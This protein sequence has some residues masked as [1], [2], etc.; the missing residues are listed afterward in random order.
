MRF[1]Y[2]VI[3]LLCCVSSLFAQQRK[4][5][6]KL[7]VSIVVDQLRTDFLYEF[8]GLYCD[9]GFKRLLS[10][11]KVYENAYYAFDNIDRAT[12]IATL[13]TGT[14]PYVSGIVA[15]RWLD[16]K[17][18][19][20]VNC[21]EDKNCKGVYS[22][23]ALSPASLK[24]ITITDEIKRSTR[25]NAIVCSIAPDG[26]AAVLA[27]GHAADVV[28]WKNNMAGY[29]SSSS[30]YGL[31]PSWAADMNKELQGKAHKWTPMFRTNEYNNFG[32]K[33]PSSFSYSF[34]GKKNIM[35]YKTTACINDEINEMA[36]AFLE[37]S[38]AGKDDVVDCLALVYYAGNYD[39][40]PMSHRPIEVQDIYA[41][42]DRNL[43]VLFDELD[44][45]FGLENVV[46]S[47]SSTGYVMENG[48][49]N[50]SYRLPSG[51]LYSE[52]IQAL[53]NVFLSAKFG[54]GDYIEGVHGTQLFLDNKLI[55]RMEL[56]KMA[57]V[58]QAVE[59]LKSL[60]GVEDVFTIYRLGGMLS[61]ELQFA[62]NGYNPVGSGDLWLRLMPGWRLVEDELLVS[63]QVYR[64]P[65]MF[66][67][68]IYGAGVAHSVEDKLTP[69]NILA[70]EMARIL[71]VRRPN[72]NCLRVF[73]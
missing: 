67:M 38:D 28:L 61:P 46:V 34:D 43:A 47:L 26:D 35:T 39:G 2:C 18:L 44:K 17:S 48:D 3:A 29:W 6:P 49:E 50:S 72:D 40:A 58:S 14:N 57:V 66:P 42:L 8:E 68:V 54:K 24:S 73:E 9:G 51:T 37:N 23:E 53:L 64:S 36:F 21:V 12:A 25:G 10:G 32:E 16:R 20:V 31:Y 33:A 22:N 65:V 7:Y 45:R 5:A 13:S 1:K 55:E 27:G 69:A 60:D 56:D 59:F 52:R 41:R 71:R 63:R 62:K 70:T 19:R 30:Y 4:T 11:G 15:E